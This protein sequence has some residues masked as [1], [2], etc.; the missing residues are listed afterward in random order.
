[1]TR[2]RHWLLLFLLILTG[3]LQSC[4]SNTIPNELPKIKQAG[5][6][7]YPI[8][9]QTTAYFYGLSTKSDP[10]VLEMT[11][12]DVLRG[13]KALE[14]I[15]A[16]NP[17]NN[18]PPDGM[19]YLLVRVH[20]KALAS[21]GDALIDLHSACFSLIGKDGTVYNE[22]T[23]VAGLTPHL[24]GM[25]QGAEREGY[26]YF[27]VSKQA[28]CPYVV[29]LSG[30]N[31]GL[32]FTTDPKAVLPDDIHLEKPSLEGID[33]MGHTEKGSRSLPYSLKE[34]VAF[35]YSF[36][37]SNDY[38]ATLVLNGIKRGK[39]ALAQVDKVDEFHPGVP[40]GKEYLLATF[41]ITL[42]S[43]EKEEPMDFNRSDFA[44]VSGD[45]NIYNDFVYI[46]EY[47]DDFQTMDEGETRTG[48]LYF[49][50][51]ATDRAPRIVFLPN[52][53]GGLWFTVN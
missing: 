11:I 38:K 4:V 30:V 20:A 10:Y 14:L 48:N 17:T 32:W 24:G 45:G 33:T 27:L 47:E 22:Q 13:D 44:L 25:Y 52:Y 12:T 51:D 31:E 36:A 15:K 3:A 46:D 16:C 28:N 50:V 42:Q 6:R 21:K 26:I 7:E 8:P 34:Q 37:G 43:R 18:D 19:E 5:N 40:K 23:A 53:N 9:I 41:T 35:D 39:G 49:L 2:K 1:M 29:F